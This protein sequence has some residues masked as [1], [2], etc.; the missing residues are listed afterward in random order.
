ML[1]QVSNT[2]SVPT[3]IAI[4]KEIEEAYPTWTTSE[5]IDNLSFAASLNSPL[6][7][8]L[9]A[10]DSGTSFSPK[11][12]L[13]QIDI[14]SLIGTINQTTYYGDNGLCEVGISLDPSTGRKVALGH[15]ISGISAALYDPG[16]TK[17]RVIDSQTI[18]LLR[19]VKFSI[20]V[21]N[22]DGTLAPPSDSPTTFELLPR[23]IAIDSLYAMTIAG[24]IAQTITEYQELWIE[25]FYPVQIGGIGTEASS[26]ELYGNIDGFWMGTWLRTE[27]GQNV[28]M[29]MSLPMTDPDNVKLSTVLGEYYGTITVGNR[30]LDMTTEFE[31]TLISN[32]RFS[33]FLTMLKSTDF[34][35]NTLVQSIIYQLVNSQYNE[36]GICDFEATIKA[37]T[38]FESWCISEFNKLRNA[39]IL[40][41]DTGISFIDCINEYDDLSYLSLSNYFISQS[42]NSNPLSETYISC[43]SKGSR[44]LSFEY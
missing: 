34:R 21:L 33:N 23:V 30:V 2:I 11:G 20:P 4:I 42:D 18:D 27:E 36:I 44:M 28:C 13:T 31:T 43:Y 24:D 15:A 7:Q 8:V 3:A 37:Y 39:S 14:D 17:A 9:F 40:S 10:S 22:I 16:E 1:S 5:L 32:L 19:G 38:A 35:L 29:S 26:A 6:N 25:E 41:R 12:K